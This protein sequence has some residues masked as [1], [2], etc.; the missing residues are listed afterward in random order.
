MTI[1]GKPNIV[2]PDPVLFN[3]RTYEQARRDR[4]SDCISD[5]LNDEECDARRIYEDIIADINDWVDYHRRFAKKAEDL[6]DLLLGHRPFVD[7][8]G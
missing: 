1:E 2:S 7:F 8:Q 6:R 5:Y 3:Q 4:L